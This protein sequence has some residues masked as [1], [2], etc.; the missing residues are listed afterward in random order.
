MCNR[1]LCWLAMVL[2]GVAAPQAWSA[3]ELNMPPDE[4]GVIPPRLAQTGAFADTQALT[5]NPMLPAY[6]LNFPFWSDG[7]EKRRWLATPRGATIQFSPTGEWHFPAG[8]VFVKHFERAGRRL[9]TRL[10]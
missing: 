9:E 1:W 4:R 10:L 7:A 5:P 8:T 2:G 3:A 6:A